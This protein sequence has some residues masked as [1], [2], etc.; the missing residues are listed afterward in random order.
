M[1]LHLAG[2]R[3]GER[4][5]IQPATLRQLHTPQT[6]IGARPEKPQFAPES[7]AM[8][9]AADAYRGHNRLS[10]GGAIDGLIASLGDRGASRGC[11]D[12]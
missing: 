9:W 12:P 11:A 4:Q 2:G 1:Q 3:V 5:L 8:G 10:H 6:V 7:Y